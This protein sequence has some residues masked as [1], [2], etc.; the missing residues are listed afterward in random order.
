MTWKQRKEREQGRRWGRKEVG[1]RLLDAT[2]AQ[3]QFVI[4]LLE[5]E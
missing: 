5:P 1:E 2:V 4:T 3:I